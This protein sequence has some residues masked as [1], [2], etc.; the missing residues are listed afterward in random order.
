MIFAFLSFYLENK[1][2]PLVFT[3]KGVA[4]PSTAAN[5]W[6]EIESYAWEEYK[7][8]N[9]VPGP[10]VFSASEGICLKINPKS[11]LFSYWAGRGGNIMTTSLI[12]FSPEQIV[13]AEHIFSKYS[14][15]K[16]S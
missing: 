16:M 14:V 13:E 8:M 12:F 1:G 7:G 6:N 9:K 3:D 15:P 10:T 11:I 4:L 2:N 5:F